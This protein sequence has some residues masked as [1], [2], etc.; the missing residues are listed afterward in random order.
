MDENIKAVESLVKI[1]INLES[2]NKKKMKVS[3]KEQIDIINQMVIHIQKQLIGYECLKMAV[4]LS[5]DNKQIFENT[6]K[7][8]QLEIKKIGDE[9]EKSTI[10]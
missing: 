4:M 6:E 8:I 9:N 7:F 5:E 10:Y 1:A 2:K 3:K